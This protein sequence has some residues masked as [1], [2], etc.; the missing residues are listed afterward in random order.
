MKHYLKKKL[1][2]LGAAGLLLQG[3]DAL[4]ADGTEITAGTVT[5]HDL[6][7]LALCIVG[8]VAMYQLNRFWEEQN[9]NK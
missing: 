2:T 5:A 7:L 8:A 3:V 6:L 1:W 9:S 4:A